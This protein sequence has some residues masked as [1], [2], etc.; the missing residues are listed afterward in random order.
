MTHSWLG[1]TLLLLAATPVLAAEGPVAVMPFKNANG[2]ARLDWLRVG[3]AETMITD[4]KR[5]G[6]VSVVE[7]DQIDKAL[8][9]LAQQKTAGSDEASAARV[10][11]LV[12]ARTIVVGAFQE[13]E[14]QVRISA[15]FVAVESGVVVDAAAATGPIERIFA[16]QDEVVDRLLGAPPPRRPRRKAVPKTV[17]AYQLYAQSL[18][19]GNDAEKVSWLK[20][21]IAADPEFSYAVDDLAALEKRLAAYEKVS[22]AKLGERE[23][24]LLG[25]AG[26][27][28]VAPDERLRCARELAESLAAARRYH[29]LVAL[30][31]RLT[32]LGLGTELDELVSFRLFGAYDRLRRVDQAFATGENHLKTFP[33]GIHYRELEARLRE[34]AEARRKMDSRRAEYATDLAEKRDGMAQNGVV[35]PEARLEYD[36]A[37]CIAARWNSQLNELMIDGCSQFL[38]QHAGD[39]DPDARDHVLA[40]RFFIVLALSERGDFDKARPLAEQLLAD[41]HE[42]DEDLR[43]LM[44]EWPTD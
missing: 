38:R 19:T 40:A 9:E 26:D 33:I 18:Q 31:P 24:L 25:R 28:K 1:C 37:P 2:A 12:G 23:K 32:A 43:K 7:R 14:R 15:R 35:R 39:R 29:T 6:K 44:S 5:S 8:A 17:Q 27:G 34:L 36:Y 22:T 42:W 13:A 16:L 11:K 30:A 4:L 10:G 41:T 20:Q 3:I 21:S